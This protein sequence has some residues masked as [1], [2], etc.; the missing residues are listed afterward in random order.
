MLF[1]DLAFLVVFGLLAIYM[2]KAND[3]AMKPNNV[4][5]FATRAFLFIVIASVWSAVDWAARSR[6]TEPGEKSLFS[7]VWMLIDFAQL[8]LIWAVLH[9]VND[10]WWQSVCLAAGFTLALYLDMK[11]VLGAKKAAP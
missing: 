6:Q 11:V 3:V 5:G 4:A 2:I 1:K 10:T 9:C 8:A 7:G